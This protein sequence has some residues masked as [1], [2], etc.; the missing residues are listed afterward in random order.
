MNKE[1]DK[2]RDVIEN[3]KF[4]AIAGSVSFSVLAI[5]SYILVSPDLALGM[6]VG[7][8]FMTLYVCRSIMKHSTD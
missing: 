1:V 4:A 7:G 6:V 8:A 3:A 5:A 2:E